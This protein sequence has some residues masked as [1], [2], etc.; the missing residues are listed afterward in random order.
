ML[1]FLPCVTSSKDRTTVM[2]S[3]NR[4][5][6]I[7]VLAISLA[8]ITGPSCMNSRDSGSTVTGRALQ[9]PFGNLPFMKVLITGPESTRFQ[10]TDPSGNF[11]MFHVP[12]GVYTAKFAIFGVQVYTQQL[13]IEQDDTTYVVDLPEFVTGPASVNISTVNSLDEIAVESADIWFFFD[14]GTVAH[15]ITDVEGNL[16][17]GDLPDAF[18]TIV[19]IADGFEMV[20]V[21]DVKIGFEGIPDLDF[22][23]KQVFV[24]DTGSVSGHVR[25]VDGLLIQNAYVGLFPVSQTPSIFSIPEREAFTTS[26]EYSLD[27]IPTGI[28]TVLCS[29]SGY[30][31]ETGTVFI[32][33]DGE[34]TLDFE[35]TTEESAWQS[36]KVIQSV[37]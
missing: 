4:K 9:H 26:G 33:T 34:H 27:G 22:K 37:K 2:Y 8:L 18:A 1:I 23:L 11:T 7:F 3:L 6:I 30:L 25:D 16:Q 5:F 36:N 21:E 10:I 28:Y 14:N 32:E 24:G 29:K 12:K 31:H 35:L 20:V 17:M 19:V 15:G 13:V